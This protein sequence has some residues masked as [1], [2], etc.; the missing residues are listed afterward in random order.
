MEMLHFLFRG[1]N[2]RILNRIGTDSVSNNSNTYI[3]HDTKTILQFA[4]CHPKSLQVTQ[5]S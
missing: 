3:M 1:A 2:K 5:F 4:T